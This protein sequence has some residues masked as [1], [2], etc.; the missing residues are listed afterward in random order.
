MS[1]SKTLIL[2]GAGY[3][4]LAIAS[5]LIK[6]KMNVTVADNLVYGNEF[7]VRPFLFDEQFKFK[8]YDYTKTSVKTLFE[9]DEYENVIMLAGLV[10]DP[11]TKKYPKFSQEVNGAKLRE[12]FNDLNETNIKKLIFTS[13]CSNYGLIGENET[14]DEDHKLSPLSLYAQEKVN[15]EKYI[16]ERANNFSYQSVIL[17]FSTAFGCA[18]RMRFDL[19][20]NEFVRD[21]FQE[22]VLEVYDP[23]TWRPYCHVRDFGEL[24]HLVI[25]SKNEYFGEVFNAGSD[26]NNATKRMIIENIQKYLPN[27]QV[28]YVDGGFDKR[29]Y[30]VDFSKVKKHFD[31]EIKWT[32]DKGIEE[33]IY[34][35]K[36]GFYTRNE[37][38]K[39]FYG[40]YFLEGKE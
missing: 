3:I 32:I 22:S 30:K 39:N 5:K 17:R 14:A 36:N 11:I 15:A 1:T 38:F 4:G 25:N 34:N 16:I 12:V 37:E 26:K 21:L 8:K 24:I 33:L 18:P 40:N 2:G 20:V 13:T 28:K 7:A 19:S 6:E 29:N 10:G 27:S 35:L 23:D 9:H 31:F